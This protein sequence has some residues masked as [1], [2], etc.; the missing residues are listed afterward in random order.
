M[1]VLDIVPRAF[2]ISEPSLLELRQVRHLLY[3]KDGAH[4]RL[5]VHCV[6]LPAGAG[7]REVLRV[8]LGQVVPGD[9][10]LVPPLL[11]PLL[12]LLPVLGILF[13]LKPFV[14]RD[15]L[16]GGVL[17]RTQL[18]VILLVR[19]RGLRSLL[20]GGLSLACLHLLVVL[21]PVQVL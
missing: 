16:P 6:V 20:V 10:L 17:L 4:A 5:V 21:L 9:L 14:V 1:L 19:V 7:Q 12:L 18:R 13:L 8:A 15:L 11:V 2:Q 3:A